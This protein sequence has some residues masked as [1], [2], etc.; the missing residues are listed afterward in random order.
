MWTCE[1]TIIGKLGKVHNC[2]KISTCS[3]SIIFHSIQSYTIKVNF[4]K[5]FT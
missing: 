3:L 5:L 2:L 1:G 4:L